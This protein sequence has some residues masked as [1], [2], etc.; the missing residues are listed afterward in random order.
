MTDQVVV[1]TGGVG[2]AKLVLGLTQILPPESITAIVNTGDDFRHLGLWVSPDL[3]TLLYTLSGKANAVQGWGREGETWNFM[4]ALRSLGGEDWF[5]LGDADIALH[6]LRTQGLAAGRSLAEIT[7]AFAEAWAV[8]VKMLPMSNETVETRLATDEGELAFQT[9][10]VGRRCAPRVLNIDFRGARDARPAPGV[11]EAI[12]SASAIL[13]APSNPYL[14]IDPILAVPGLKEALTQAPAPVIAVCPI[15]GGEAVKGP[16]AKLM[17]EL[18]IEVSPRAI[19]AH[20][21][22]VIDGLLLDERDAGVDPGVAHAAA[23]TMMV[24]LADRARVAEA[25]LRLAKQLRS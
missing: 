24:T 17:R 16:T 15:I 10:F 5:Q 20:Y 14:S 3:D 13:I 6:A 23:D 21:R 22:G 18:G 25:A 4:A 1:L 2:G 11:R 12:A 9:Y 7:A 19:A 8:K